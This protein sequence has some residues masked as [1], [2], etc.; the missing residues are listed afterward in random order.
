MNRIFVARLPW[1]VC[2]ITLRNHFS[3]FGPVQ[4]GYIVLDRITRRSK[5]YGFVT[6]ANNESAQNAV[7]ATH[8]IEGRQLVVSIAVDK[9]QGEQAPSTQDNVDA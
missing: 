4:D 6:F 9:R 1:S 2:K 8:E 3:K 5:G 7:A